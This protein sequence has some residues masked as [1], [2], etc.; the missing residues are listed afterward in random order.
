MVDG[1]EYKLEMRKDP[2]TGQ[3]DFAYRRVLPIPETPRTA[4]PQP[5]LVVFWNKHRPAIKDA[6]TG[7]IVFII[8][9]V[10]VAVLR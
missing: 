9:A 3:N 10:L 4:K 6:A 8:M 5:P 2:R 7:I 1:N